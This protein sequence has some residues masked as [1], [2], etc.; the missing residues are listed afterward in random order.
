MMLE[1]IIKK[2]P[3]FVASSYD[4]SREGRGG[5]NFGKN[6]KKYDYEHN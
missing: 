2:F 4:P 3:A 6:F 1:K 5:E